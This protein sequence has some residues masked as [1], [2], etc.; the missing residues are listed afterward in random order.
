VNV[1]SA[2]TGSDGKFVIRIKHRKRAKY[3]AVSVGRLWL[4]GHVSAAHRW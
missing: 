1:K 4:I 3:R 2:R